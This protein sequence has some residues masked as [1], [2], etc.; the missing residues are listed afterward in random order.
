MSEKRLRYCG[1]LY[2]L[3]A[4]ALVVAAGLLVR[5]GQRPLCVVVLAD[6]LAC[7]SGGLPALSPAVL[8]TDALPPRAR[9]VALR[10][11][12]LADVR[13]LLAAAA[14]PAPPTVQDSLNKI[15]K[16]IER[17]E[18]LIPAT[19]EVLREY[20]DLAKAIRDTIPDLRETN[21]ELQKLIKGANE[22]V[23]LVQDALKEGTV[24]ARNWGRVGERVNVL[25]GTNEDRINSIIKNLD[26]AT[27]GVADAFNQQN[28]NDLATILRNLSAGSKQFPSISR[29]TEGFLKEG[30]QTQAKLNDTLRRTDDVL[31]QLRGA[32]PGQEGKGAIRDF[33]EGAAKFN[34]T[35]TDVRALLRAI[36]QSDGTFRRIIA[37][38]ALYNHLDEAAL[39]AGRLAPHLDRI[40]HDLEIFADKLA[41]HPEAL[42]LRGAVRPSSGIKEAPSRSAYPHPKPFP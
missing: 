11:D 16:S 21:K 26:A 42:G 37:D 15:Q 12:G 27:A 6:P 22:T 4:C 28:R 19:E 5:S 32:K 30:R 3:A 31:D 29:E 14:P 8:R 23:P 25:I 9:G 17:A 20:R 33:S 18:K 41:R 2:A 36:G 7:P 39:L 24:A 34:A 1:G 40:M 35:M 13:T 38:P 10:A